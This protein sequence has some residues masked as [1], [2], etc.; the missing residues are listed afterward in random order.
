[1]YI[2][3][4][5][6]LNILYGCSGPDWYEFGDFCYKPFGDKKTWH[7]ARS[8]CRNLGADLVS[9]QEKNKHPSLKCEVFSFAATSNVW[10][11]LNDLAIPGLFMWSDE[12]IVTFTYWAPGE[13]N[14]HNGFSED[15][16]EMLHQTGR[17]ND[18]SC[19]QLNNYV[20]KMPKAH[21]P[22]PS[23]QP[24]IYGCPQVGLSRY[25]LPFR[26]LFEF[27]FMF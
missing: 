11:G 25:L 4:L 17:W 3:L 21:Y 7:N 20:C 1:K 23:V 22:L 9:I 12:H 2:V 15:C 19:T 14:N 13:P 27:H 26:H 8:S 16:V 24:T 18:K 5:R 10:T 6:S